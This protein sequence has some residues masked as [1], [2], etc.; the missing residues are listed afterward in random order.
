M[1]DLVYIIPTRGRPNNVLE[2]IEA[3]KETVELPTTRAMFIVDDDDPA[4]P[5]YE[6]VFRALDSR[7]MSKHGSFAF[8]AAYYH[9]EQNSPNARLTEII[10]SICGSMLSLF[11][12][13]AYAIGFMGDDHRPRT[14]GWDGK[15]IAALGVLG[16]GVVYGNDLIQGG[17]L[18][19]AVAM[20][21]DIPRTLGYMV[22]PTLKH[23]FLDNFWK[24]LG[25]AVSRLCYL[26]DV[27]I[28]HVHPLA[29]RTQWDQGYAGVAEHMEPDRIAYEE[30]KAH[31]FP[32]DVAKVGSLIWKKGK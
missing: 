15:L 9:T 19:T 25:E 17:N 32:E 24:D 3:W 22:P 20:T 26:E 12:P 10:N 14:E 2:L 1:N 27:V 4:K 11:E 23:M 8:G 31:Q 18:P 29:G 30:Y 7:I 13:S 5:E 16:T 28:E 21:A 6:A